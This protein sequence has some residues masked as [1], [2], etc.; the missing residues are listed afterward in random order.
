MGDAYPELPAQRELIMRVIK[1][2]EDAF[3]RTLE[4][5]IR[6]LEGAG[7]TVVACELLLSFSQNHPVAGLDGCRSTGTLFLLC[8]FAVRRPNQCRP[9]Q[10]HRGQPQRHPPSAPGSAPGAGNTWGGAVV[11][12]DGPATGDI[13]SGVEQ[14]LGI[15]RQFARNTA[16]KS[17]LSAMVIPWNSVA[18]RML[19]IPETSA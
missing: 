17:V 2:E 1:E 14:C 6:L 5:G 15:C 12:L 8:H 10:G 7:N 4:N 18:A 19:P 3:L 11:G 9:S 16:I 13:D